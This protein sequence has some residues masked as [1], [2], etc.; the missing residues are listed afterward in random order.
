MEKDVLKMDDLIG[1]NTSPTKPSKIEQTKLAQSVY[2]SKQ[3]I[4]LQHVQER[5]GEDA[6][7]GPKGHGLR[8]LRCALSK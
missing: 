7:Y 2:L 6:G 8:P 4:H 5:K 3:N 1:G